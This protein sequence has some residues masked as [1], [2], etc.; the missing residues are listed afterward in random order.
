MWV[1]WVV[2][3]C[4]RVRVWACESVGVWACGLCELCG[5]CGCVGRV[6]VWGCELVCVCGCVGV[7]VARERCQSLHKT[8]FIANHLLQP[9]AHLFHPAAAVGAPPSSDHPGRAHQ[10]SGQRVRVRR[11]DVLAPPR[12]CWPHRCG[13]HPPAELRGWCSW[14]AATIPGEAGLDNP[15]NKYICDIAVR[16]S[17]VCPG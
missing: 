13:Y 12:C 16:H 8:F 7:W 10:W 11:H 3:V 14:L 1:V 4:G 15:S 6:D 5:A 2:W 9:P 17:C